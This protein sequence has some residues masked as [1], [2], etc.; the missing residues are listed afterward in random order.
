M[1]CFGT[2]PFWNISFYPRGAEYNALGEAPHDL[3]ILREGTA[4]NG[5]MVEAEDGPTLTRTMIVTARA[6]NDGMSDRNFGMSISMF[7]EAHDGNDVRTGCCTMQV[8]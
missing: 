7:T 5:Y 4:P 1:S 2:E 6:C 8:N 3:T